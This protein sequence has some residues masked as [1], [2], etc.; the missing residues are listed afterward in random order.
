MPNSSVISRVNAGLAR[1]LS[2]HRRLCRGI[3]E[4]ERLIHNDGFLKDPR[5][6]WLLHQRR[7][8]EEEQANADARV[9]PLGRM[10]CEVGRLLGAS[11]IKLPPPSG[12]NNLVVTR[13]F[14]QILQVEN[15]TPRKQPGPMPA[16]TPLPSPERRH[17]IMFSGRMPRPETKGSC[18]KGSSQSG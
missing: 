16:P 10:G 13:T 8:T 1:C 3:A 4:L 18:S 15:T 14:C 17:S 9:S 5:T 11:N 7:Q 6:Q 2:H 12:K